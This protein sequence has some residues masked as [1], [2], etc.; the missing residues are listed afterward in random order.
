M[1]E[2]RTGEPVLLKPFEPESEAV[3][4]AELLREDATEELITLVEVEAPMVKLLVT[5]RDEKGL[6]FS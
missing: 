6:V 2:P 1:E 4:G 3:P 5:T